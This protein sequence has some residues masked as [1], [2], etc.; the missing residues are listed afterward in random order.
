[1]SGIDEP[2]LILVADANRAQRLTTYVSTQGRKVMCRG[3]PQHA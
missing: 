3:C 1:M 2:V